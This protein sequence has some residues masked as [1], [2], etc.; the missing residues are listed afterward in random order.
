MARRRNER[1]LTG[2]R[3][4]APVLRMVAAY[5]SR[6]ALPPD[7]LGM[8]ID[9]MHAA[10]SRLGAAPSRSEPNEGAPAKLTTR[11]QSRSSITPAGLKSFEDGRLYQSLHRHLR[12]RGLDPEAYRSKWGLPPD[13]PMICPAYSVRRSAIARQHRFGQASRV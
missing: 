8:L 5:V 4:L 7:R 12:R 6:N 9:T 3:P 1:R 13:Y 10:V 11:M 2:E